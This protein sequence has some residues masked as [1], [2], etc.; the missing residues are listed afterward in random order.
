[1]AAKSVKN[2]TVY[3]KA[4][5]LAKEFFEISNSFPSERRYLVTNK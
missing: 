2:T 5:E 4:F 3:K 1:M